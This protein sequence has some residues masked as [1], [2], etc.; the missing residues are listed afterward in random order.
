MLFV[1]HVESGISS[2]ALLLRVTAAELRCTS[3]NV[4]RISQESRNTVRRSTHL[5]RVRKYER[6]L[7]QHQRSQQSKLDVQSVYKEKSATTHG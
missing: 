1:M 4:P 3:V 5:I 2:H 6:S 7:V